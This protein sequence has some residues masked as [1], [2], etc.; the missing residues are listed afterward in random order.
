MNQKKVIELALEGHNIFLTGQAG[1][2]KTYT[3]KKIINEFKKKKKSVAVTAS[4]G[5]A[6]THLNGT[7][8]H[9][10]SGA[11]IKD[12]FIL[13]DFYKIK[14]NKYSFKR[15]FNTD[16][17]IIDEISMIQSHVLDLIEEICRFIKNPDKIFGGI[18]IILC[19]D[20]FQL[21]PVSKNKKN[22]C[23]NSQAWQILNLKICYLNKVYRQQNDLK[24][25]E[26]LN[27]IRNNSIKDEHKEILS[28]LSKN[29][30]N[31]KNAI[32]LYCKNI[33]VDIE[34]KTELNK[35]KEEV[36]ILKNKTSGIDFKIKSLQ[37]NILAEETL[38]LKKNSKI[39]LL[40]NNFKKNYRNGTL[41]KIINF[42]E[43]EDEKI[44]VETLNDKRRIEIEPYTWK[45][46]EY[47]PALKNNKQVA[48]ISQYPIKLAWAIT[49][50]KSQGSSF[51]FVNLDLSDVFIENMGYVALSRVTSLDGL[52]LKDFNEKSFKIDE[53]ILKIDKFFQKESK[54]NE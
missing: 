30:K 17:L 48:S 50:H 44:I 37:K 3:L 46:E 41:C 49:V 32:N 19:G 14:N 42:D 35:M 33:N 53:K 45:I 13:D 28:S 5:V 29:K 2:G 43:L 6:S 1:T 21:P 31:K 54:K 34:N 12:K 10:W 7:T 24:F 40:V 38:L 16:V 22:Y 4:T 51:D 20:F 8:I 9:S 26:I 52:Y 15:I 36:F 25:I 18:Q 23:F 39:M 11:G 27:S 47:D